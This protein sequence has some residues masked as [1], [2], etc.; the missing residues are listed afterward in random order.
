MSIE[1]FGANYVAMLMQPLPTGWRKPLLKKENG[2]WSSVIECTHPLTLRLIKIEGRG[3]EPSLAWASMRWQ[4]Q[5]V[6]P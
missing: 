4:I 2:L 5:G 6:L 3:P 1:D